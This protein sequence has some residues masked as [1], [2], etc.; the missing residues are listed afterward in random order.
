MKKHNRVF[1]MVALVLLFSVFSSTIY[2]KENSMA[3]VYGEEVEDENE[4][5]KMLINIL[6]L[7]SITIDENGKIVEDN[8]STFGWSINGSIIEP[9]QTKYYFPSNEDRGFN[10]RTDEYIKVDVEFGRRTTFQIGLTDGHFYIQT[11][12]SVSIQLRPYSDGYHKLFIKNMGSETITVNG[13]IE[14]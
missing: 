5:G 8:I 12:S 2:A 6:D 1:L 13:T 14:I 7:D 11:G 4:K 3:S 10:L 9:G